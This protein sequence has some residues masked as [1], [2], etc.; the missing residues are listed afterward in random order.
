MPID[1][2]TYSPTLAQTS[3]QLLSGS[4]PA[5][6]GAAGTVAPAPPPSPPTSTGFGSNFLLLI[7]LPLAFVILMQIMQG[8]RDKKKRDELLGA[9]KKHDRVVTSGG[10]I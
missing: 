3:D 2:M 6:A 8:R 7:F 9:L 10:I 5:P 1:P 4:A